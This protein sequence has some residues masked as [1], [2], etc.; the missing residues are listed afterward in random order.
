MDQFVLPAWLEVFLTQV[1]VNNWIFVRPPPKTLCNLFWL[2]SLLC[3]LQWRTYMYSLCD[4]CLFQLKFKY[5][6]KFITV[7]PQKQ[8]IPCTIYPNCATCADGIVC[9]TCIADHFFDLNSSMFFFTSVETQK[10]CVSCSFDNCASCVEGPKC[11][12]CDPL[13][14]FNYSSSML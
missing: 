3:Y 1:Q 2:H 13:F 5:F 14:Y 10:P 4:Q 12:I 11:S 7:L 8:C 6:I 9:L